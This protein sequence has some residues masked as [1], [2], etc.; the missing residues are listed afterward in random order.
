VVIAPS[1]FHGPMASALKKASACKG[2]LILRDVFPQWALD[3]G[4]MGRGLPYWC[5]A[6]VAR[7]QYAVA[8][9][10]GVQTPGNLGYFADW[11]RR[12]RKLEVLQNWLDAPAVARCPTRVDQTPLAGRKVLVYAGN[13]GVAQ[14]MGIVLDLAQAL[15]ASPMWV[16]SWWVAEVMWR[17]SSSKRRTVDWT[18]CCFLTR[19]I[20]TKYPTC[21]PSALQVS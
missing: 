5:F 11:Q 17:T 7:Y 1:I 12:G 21:M 13:M 9:V 10:I 6:A 2:Y 4:L 19:S 3:M 18:T 8:D 14:G 16:F 15:P 20:R